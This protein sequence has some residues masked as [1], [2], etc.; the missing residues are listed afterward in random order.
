MASVF[1]VR[2]RPTSEG[3][4][5]RISL[6]SST[7]IL[8]TERKKSLRIRV[9]SGLSHSEFAEILLHQSMDELRERCRQWGRMRISLKHQRVKVLKFFVYNKANVYHF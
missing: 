6:T 7:Y 9:L 2:G 1:P 4:S 8:W 5:K 3:I